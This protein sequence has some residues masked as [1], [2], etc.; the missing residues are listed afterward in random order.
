M[1]T[2]LIDCCGLSCPEPVL[3]VRQIL[4]DPSLQEVRVKVSA[5]AAR[6]NVSRAARNLGWQVGVKDDGD[7]FLLTLTRRAGK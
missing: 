3:R 5:A 1:S 7:C 6:D 2:K 4:Q